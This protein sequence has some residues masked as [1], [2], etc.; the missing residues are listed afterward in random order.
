MAIH[1]SILAWE[2]PMDRGVWQAVVHGVTKERGTTQQLNTTTNKRNQGF[3]KKWQIPDLGQETYKMNLE[4]FVISNSKEAIK[5]YQGHIFW[6][7][8]KRLSL[9]KDGM[10]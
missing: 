3:L 2:I 6:C 7:Q 5:D 9:A 4:Y 1:P 10:E 8:W